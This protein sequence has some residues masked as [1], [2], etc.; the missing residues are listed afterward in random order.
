MGRNGCTQ[1]CWHD[2]GVDSFWSSASASFVSVWHYPWR[3]A[4]FRQKSIF[5]PQK[6]SVEQMA[7][8]LMLISELWCKASNSLQ[9]ALVPHWLVSSYSEPCH[10][11]AALPSH[12]NLVWVLSGCVYSGLPSALQAVQNVLFAVFCEMIMS[13][14]LGKIPL[15]PTCPSSSSWM[16][17]FSCPALNCLTVLSCPAKPFLSALRVLSLSSLHLLLASS[18]RRR[19][20]L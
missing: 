8:L 13:P 18:Q 20:H 5:L 11:L 1:H 17:L 6:T 15:S 19:E 16:Q 10:V 14:C 7:S 9:Q 2:P 4:V 12:L 3:R